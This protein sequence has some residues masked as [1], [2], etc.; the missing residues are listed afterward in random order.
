M[1]INPTAALYAGAWIGGQ[2][3]GIALGTAIAK[4]VMPSKQV[5]SS[6]P[7]KYFDLGCELDRLGMKNPF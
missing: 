1:P 5:R 6:S 7:T 4:K 2:L 3:G